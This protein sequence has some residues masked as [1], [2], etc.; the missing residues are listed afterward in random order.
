[1]DALNE[2]LISCL[3]DAV[4]ERVLTRLKAEPQIEKIVLTAEETGV[5]IG[6]TERAVKQM[7]Y[8]GKL[9]GGLKIG[10][11]LGFDKRKIMA[12]LD[13]EQQ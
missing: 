10:G 2:A 13:E 5:M 6:R 3:A 9:P 1:M 8:N 11:K 7:H 4:A 12:W